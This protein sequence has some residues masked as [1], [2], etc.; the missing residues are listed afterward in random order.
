MKHRLHWL[1]ATLLAIAI[2]VGQSSLNS[3][4]AAPQAACWAGGDTSYR[5]GE[6]LRARREYSNAIICW[7]NAGNHPKAHFALGAA[8]L[9][10]EGTRKDYATARFH[11]QRSGTPAAL[12]ELGVMAQWGYGRNVDYFMARWYYSSAMLGG[13]G[14]AAANYGFLQET[15]KGG[16]M[17]KRGAAKS[18]RTAADRKS[19]YGMR[20]L[21]VCYANGFGTPVDFKAARYWLQRC[22]AN[23]PF[24]SDWSEQ[25]RCRGFLRDLDERVAG[26]SP[27]RRYDG[28]GSG[29]S[30]GRYNPSEHQ[31]VCQSG[32]CGPSN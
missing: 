22:I 8:F 25:T 20:S 32:G 2:L 11:F 6:R 17:D 19:T 29:S 9:Y 27:A 13:D 24:D 26:R 28:G 23:A 31:G 5:E 15:G 30:R 1:K 3:T 12:R 16:P 4:V 10:G 7:K 18:Y 21:A 14:P